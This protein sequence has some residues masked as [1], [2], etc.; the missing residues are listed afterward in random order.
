[1][2]KILTILCFFS[3]FGSS[4]CQKSP[5]NNLLVSTDSTAAYQ[6][7]ASGHFHGSG[8]NHT[9]YPI[10]SLLANIDQLN[11]SNSA[12]IVCLGDLFLDVST[13]IPFFEKSFFSKL[14][15]PLF[16]TVGNHD[17]S[18][19]IYQDNFGPTNFSFTLGR[20]RHL[21][22]DTESGNGS[23]EESQLK[24][25]EE[26]E[27]DVKKGLVRQVFI[28]CHR[29]IWV[30]HYSNLDGLFTSNTQSILGN[31]FSKS[32]FPHIENI[33]K[34]VPIHWFSGSIG[35]APASFFYHKDPEVDITYIATAIRGL[36]RDA[37]LKVKLDPAGKVE[38]E[39]I[40]LTGQSLE[41]LEYYDANYWKTTSA[42]PPYNYKL[43]PYYVKLVVLH[44]AFWYGVITTIVLILC[45]YL[46][47]RNRRKRKLV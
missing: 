11:S 40:S 28:Y 34:I 33:A 17:L 14:N 37:W 38:Y 9:G 19:T 47:F 12:F 6:F 35:S 5:F 8:T 1:M 29:T 3:F 2:R 23:F 42:K 39:T 44:R 22:F 26:V 13:D 7:I 16:N 24:M 31:N 20:D 41:K 43:I 46:L 10:N 27:S 21:F 30:K 15:I 18:G 32:V 36:K 45:G 25:L 4:F